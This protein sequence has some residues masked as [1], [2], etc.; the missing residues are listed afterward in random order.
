M[1]RFNRVTIIGLGL[2][3]GSLGMAIRR[4]RLAR[5][6]VGVS[7]SRATLRLAKARG[8]IDWGT[9]DAQEAVEAADL[10][11][12]ATPVDTIVPQAKRLA[13]L[14]RKG[15]ILT[16]VG[17]VKSAI[18]RALDQGLPRGVAFVGGHPL[19]GS[20]QRGIEAASPT[21]FDRSVCLLTPTARTVPQALARVRQLWR[22]IVGQVTLLPPQ[23]HDR[24]LA[25]TSHLPHLLA[26]CLAAT[27]KTDRL[28]RL[29][30]SALDMTRVAKS[31]PDL[32]DDIFAGNR[33]E[34]LA[35]IR[36]F[37]RHWYRVRAQLRRGDRSALRRFLADAKSKRDAL[38]RR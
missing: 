7:R 14:M 13:R 9:T 35:A 16:D 4:R 10:V 19:A 5:D 2:I 8:A 37:E 33:T 36:R 31:D 27:L 28:G 20:E 38:E 3:G 6:V 29:P 23:V 34:L 26:F 30:Q 1:A 12:L 15:S 18:V 25:D 32:W 24:L 21:L 17:S 11:I 22:P